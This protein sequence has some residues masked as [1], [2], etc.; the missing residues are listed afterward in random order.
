MGEGQGGQ[1]QEETCSYAGYAE[2]SYE[3]QGGMFPK[4]GLISSTLV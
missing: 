4:S 2:E 3:L 1:G